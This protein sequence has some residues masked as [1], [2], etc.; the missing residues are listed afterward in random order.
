MNAPEHTAILFPG[1]G[2]PAAP[3]RDAVAAL[4][5]ALLE[6]A[7]EHCAG[8]DPF[9]RPGEDTA[10][11]Q[12]AVYCAAI[13]AYE[14]LGRPAAA[15]F[16]G[17]SLG[18]LSALVAAGSLGEEDGLEVVAARGKAMREAAAGP[19]AGG[20]VAFRAGES[21]LREVAA[22]HGVSVANLNAPAQTVLSGDIESLEAATTE[23]AERGI[24]GKRLPVAAAFHSP[25]MAPAAE[26]LAAA[27][28]GVDLRAPGATVISALSGRPMRDPRRELVA[29]LTGPVRWVSVIQR[30][31][32]EGVTRYVEAG[33]GKALGRMTGQILADPGVVRIDAA[34]VPA[35]EATG[36]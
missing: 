29:A 4:K 7:G 12:L 5:P 16:A 18:E 25:R 11:D 34:A 23:L 26:R 32:S 36:A 22:A 1:Q 33:P 3:W 2:A 24:R 6:R 20:M 35:L 19:E 8:E 17:H 31:E 30:L 13:A 28:D 10:H 9:E 14:S 15:C 27:L 21:E